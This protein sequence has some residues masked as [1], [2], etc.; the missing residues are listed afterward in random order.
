MKFRSTFAGLV[1]LGSMSVAQAS[2]VDVSYTVSGS[3][4]A[5]L[6]DFSFTNNIGPDIG[7]YY[8]GVELNVLNQSPFYPVGWQ[9]GPPGGLNWFNNGGSNTNYNNTWGTCADAQ[10]TTNI[11]AGQNLSG[12][13]VLDTGLTARTSV[14]WFA[15][16][17][18]P[19]PTVPA[20]C[21]FNCNAQFDNPGFEGLAAPAVVPIPA[22]AW[23]F[24]SAL[25][26]MGVIRRK[27]GS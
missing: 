5:W 14:S 25:G 11:D 4:G 18:G 24:P 22:A 12:F 19:T 10:C 20:G 2:S 8:V 13:Q 27:I 23:L 9:I 6:Y 15:L 17:Y 21:S 7:I 3:A 1:L 26:L 16:A